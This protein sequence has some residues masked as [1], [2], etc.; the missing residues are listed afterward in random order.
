MRN[1][2]KALS[3]IAAASVLVI[4]L[5][6]C[7]SEPDV[8]DTPDVTTPPAGATSLSVDGGSTDVLIDMSFDEMLSSMGIEFGISGNT[9]MNE[10]I[11][12]IPVTGGELFLSEDGSEVTGEI[13]HEGSGIT[14]AAD[15]TM[16]EISDLSIDT[17]SGEVWGEVE[18]DGASEDVI[19]DGDVTDDDGVVE[20]GDDAE[21]NDG[22]TG[23]EDRV[24]IF[25]LDMTNMEDVVWENGVL[26]LNGSNVMLSADTAAL[27]STTFPGTD[28]IMADTV[29]G[30]VDVM[31]NATE[32]D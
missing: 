22:D 5:A 28:A 31:V 6:G 24:L 2:F 11:V 29:I 17:E 23:D 15:G 13:A 19:E 4:G 30:E 9:A 1:S 14:F 25:T 32:E 8:E 16:L 12:S 18:T 27:L 7:T 3:G 10:G 20:G 21:G 26:T